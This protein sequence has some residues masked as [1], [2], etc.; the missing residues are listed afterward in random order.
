MPIKMIAIDMDDTLLNDEKQITEANITAVRAAVKSGITVLLAT[1]RMYEAALPYARQL[2]LNVPLIC[3]NGALVKGSTDGQILFEHTM[4]PAT[5]RAVFQYGRKI[6]LHM[7]G[8][9]DGQV[10]TDKLNADSRRYSK[11]INLPVREIGSKLADEPHKTYKI[12]GMAE[13]AAFTA[14][15]QA[16][17]TEFSEQIDITTSI[18]YYMEILTP[19]IDK[20]TAVA[21]L[22]DR[23]GFSKDQIMCIGDSLND[24]AMLTNAG[25]GV[26][27]ANAAPEIRQAATW[28]VADNNRSGVAEAITKIL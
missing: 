13:P 18:K 24:L 27:V 7:Q 22:A 8:Y 12:L 17:H 28:T 19:G 23:W 20:W 3:Y 10:F 6:G 11:M 4:D 15:W 16:L 5:S 21:D 2:G 25:T 1:G 14:Q 26:A 9:W